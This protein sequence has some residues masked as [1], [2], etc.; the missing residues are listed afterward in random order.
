MRGVVLSLVAKLARLR[1]SKSPNSFKPPEI[2]SLAAKAVLSREY[3]AP[4]QGFTLCF[5]S[6]VAK[7]ARLRETEAPKTSL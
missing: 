2:L 7:I 6:L 3:T 1:E 5:L 4:R